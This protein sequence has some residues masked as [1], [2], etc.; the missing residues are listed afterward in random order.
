MT[1]L[2]SRIL[3]KDVVVGTFC[4]IPHP[5]TIQ[6]VAGAGWD[7]IVIDAEHSQIDRGDLEPLLRAAQVGQTP[8]I[9]RV[10]ANDRVWIGSTLDAGAAGILVPSV[11]TAAE[12]RAAIAATRYPP[13]GTRGVGPGRASGYGTKINE[14][15]AS[16]N[17]NIVLAIQLETAEGLANIEEIAAVEGIDAIYIGPGDLA[18]SLGALGPEGR[19]KLEAAIAKI[20]DCC[21]R[22][23]RA[24]GIFNMTPDALNESIARGLTFVTLVSDAVFLARALGDGAEAARK[25]RGITPKN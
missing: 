7:F 3:A 8:A 11:N 23:G 5:M 19:S 13:L 2:R 25:A 14:V 9:V 6:M 10:P 16:A 15:L 12:A 18:V 4:A 24:V 17:T 20:V 1:T 21:K 22:H